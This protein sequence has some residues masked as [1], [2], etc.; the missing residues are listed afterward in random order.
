MFDDGSKITL[1]AQIERR[2]RSLVVYMTDGSN[3]FV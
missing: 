1:F 3:L 2:I